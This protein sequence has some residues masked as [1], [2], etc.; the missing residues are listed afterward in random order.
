LIFVAV[1]SLSLAP[2]RQPENLVFSYKVNP[3]DL[4]ADDEPPHLMKLCDFGLAELDHI[5]VCVLKK[6]PIKFEK[7]D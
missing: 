1:V 5:D 4:V 2:V 3:I 7:P 6:A